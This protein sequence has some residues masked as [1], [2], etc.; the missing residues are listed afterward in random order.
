[1]FTTATALFTKS[2]PAAVGVVLLMVAIILQAV[3][4]APTLTVNVD[5][6][7]PAT[8]PVP[9]PLSF[10]EIK[11]PFASAEYL[12]SSNVSNVPSDIGIVHTLLPLD[13]DKNCL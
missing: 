2:L 8:N 11:A 3:L 13:V 1:M 4:A 6:P 10:N 12:S 5:V 9:L 7:K